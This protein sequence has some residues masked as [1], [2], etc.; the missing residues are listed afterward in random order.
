ME[1]AWGK[2]KQKEYNDIN[3]HQPSDEYSDAM[4]ADGMAQVAN[5]LFKIGDQMANE[6]TFPGWKSNSEFKAVREKSMGK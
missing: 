4:D 1:T 6:T 3:Y 2:Q 5:L